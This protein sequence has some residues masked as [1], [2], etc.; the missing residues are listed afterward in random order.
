MAVATGVLAAA[1]QAACSRVKAA[2]Y[3]HLPTSHT[4]PPCHLRTPPPHTPHEL[5]CPP[6]QSIT[7][8]SLACCSPPLRN[9]HMHIRPSPGVRA[10]PS[11]VQPPPPPHTCIHAP[12]VR[13]KPLRGRDAA[14]DGPSRRNLRLHLQDPGQVPVLRDHEA[15]VVIHGEARAVRLAREA[16]VAVVALRRGGGGGF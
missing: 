11:H 9:T 8:Y 10:K 4:H 13:V 5:Q 7:C 6:V 16:L 1:L 3:K 14:A 12:G 15:L 2:H